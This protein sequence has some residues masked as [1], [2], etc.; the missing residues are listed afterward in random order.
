MNCILLLINKGNI[1]KKLF[2][3]FCS[4]FKLGVG[5]KNVFDKKVFREC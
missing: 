4:Y 5:D 2:D 1:I 3:G